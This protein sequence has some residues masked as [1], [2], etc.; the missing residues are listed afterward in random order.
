MNTVAI[1][2]ELKENN[3]DFEWYPTTKEIV[4]EIF[5]DIDKR[6]NESY[7]L[8]KTQDILDIGAGDGNFFEL[9]KSFKVESENYKTLHFNKYAI[10]KSSILIE[11][12]E[13][14]IVIVGTDFYNQSLIDKKM[15]I[16][17]CNPPYSEYDKWVEKI[18][19]ESNSEYVYMVIPE[20]WEDNKKIKNVI[21]NRKIKYNILGSFDFLE[22]EYR[23][24]RVKIHIVK[25]D[26]GKE[27]HRTDPFNIWFDSFFNI[28]ADESSDSEYKKEA[29]K[30]EQIKNSLVKG[31]NLIERLEEL[32]Q[33]DFDK[34]IKNYKL[35]ENLDY[36][37]FK[38]L[39]VDISN[40]KKSLKLKISG[41]KNF[42]WN[43]LFDNLDKLTSRLTTNSRK[44]LLEKLS[45]HI[46]VDFTSSNAYAIIIWAIK[47]VNIYLEDQLKDI[48][49]RLAHKDNMINYKSNKRLVTDAW[50]YT[51]IKEH[52]CFKFDYRLIFKS[53][54]SFEIYSNNGLSKKTND[55]IDDIITIAHNLGFNVIGRSCD[56]KWYPGRNVI[57]YCNEKTF[58]E[59]RV[60]KNGNI[61]CKFNQEFMKKF[62]IEA[63]RLFGWI[64]SPQE[65]SV[66]L[67]IPLEETIQ[68]FNSNTQLTMN[69]VKLLI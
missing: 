39:G 61:H 29:I 58:M 27:N 45:K 9:L 32:Y 51:Q 54:S 23:K 15:D 33:E 59:I 28:K 22:S 53:Y 18:I 34:L 64:K 55:Y 62:N 14:D 3:E 21:E 50:R 2:K 16:I 36:I 47:N 56:Y 46:T 25:F 10:E 44:Q 60:Y 17:F 68:Y 11:K 69:H 13:S 40:L 65:A 30:K 42:Y 7:G 48:Y 20:R 67:D 57:F 8:N 6:I 19:T 63:G 38:E 26:F 43:E 66:E 31:Q 1:V 52:T 24:A 4:K 49:L 12:M 37:L 41:L 5:N 35:L